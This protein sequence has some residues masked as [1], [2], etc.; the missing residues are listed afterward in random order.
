VTPL[1]DS[2]LSAQASSS[3]STVPLTG[4]YDSKP[5]PTRKADLPPLDSVP[6][7]FFDTS[8]NLA[9]PSTWAELVNDAGPSSP[10]ETP[11][12]DALSTHL[13]TLERH[14]V[15][16]ITLRSTSFFSALS[17]LQD[18]HSES[19]SCLS[20]ISELQSS[21]S[22][23]GSKQA[24]KGLDIIDAQEKLRVLRITEDG[25]RTMGELEEMLRIARNVVDHGDWA[26][27]LGCLEDVVRWWERH[28]DFHAGH[29]N[30]DEPTSSLPLSTL[31]A[32]AALPEA[33]DEL[34]HAI[35][36]QLEASLTTLLLSILS[37]AEPAVVIDNDDVQS[38][39]EPILV[40]LVR[41]GHVDGL[42]GLWKEVVTVA[43]RE[44]SRKVS[45][46]SCG[47]GVADKRSS[48]CLW[49]PRMT[50]MWMVERVR[51]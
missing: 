10:R 30:G 16:E 6:E 29:V 36:E 19:A 44:G 40:G 7:L 28:G 48:T 15:H 33:F 2:F 51:R 24:R 13:D 23:V 4:E 45:W 35:A 20:R 31:P 49:H 41:C 26:A 12:Q 5:P 47:S 34:T 8:F 50:V 1:Y 39:V 37:S 14:L 43:V 21:L 25:V 32:L 17:N 38:S 27:G 18:L 3:S 22:E 42:G 9:N 46:V 11:G